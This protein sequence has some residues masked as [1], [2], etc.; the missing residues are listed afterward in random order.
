M[1]DDIDEL[2]RLAERGDE[3]AVAR[4]LGGQRA[5]LRAMV[6][7][8]MDARIRGRCDPSDIVQEAMLDAYRQLPDYLASRPLPFYPWLRQITWQQLVAHHRRHLKYQVRSVLREDQVWSCASDCSTSQLAD[9][10]ADSV[11][12]PSGQVARSEVQEKVL[13]ELNSLPEGDREIL[14]LRILEQLSSQ[15]TAAVLNVS[16]NAVRV[17]QFR[18]LKR[19]KTR[20]DRI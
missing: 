18:A 15:E 10:L 19:L 4:L 9:R 3:T 12:S 2:L 11:I 16:E 20:L 7:L 14:V 13:N 6:A 5:R 8:H 17:R 1:S